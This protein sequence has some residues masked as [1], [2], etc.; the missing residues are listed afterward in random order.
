MSVNLSSIVSANSAAD[1]APVFSKQTMN[2][3]SRETLAALSLLEFSPVY[4]ACP[5]VVAQS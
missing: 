4:V 1:T 2:N 3:N 5:E